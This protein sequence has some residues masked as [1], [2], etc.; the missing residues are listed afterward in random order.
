MVS[1][2]LES[3][4]VQRCQESPREVL[5]L[6]TVWKHKTGCFHHA[7][8]FFLP[9]ILKTKRRKTHQLANM[10][11]IQ[12]STA[13]L[14]T[15]CQLRYLSSQKT[16][17]GGVLGFPTS[18]PSP[19]WKASAAWCY[20]PKVQWMVLHKSVWKI[21]GVLGFGQSFFLLIRETIE[22]HGMKMNK[23]TYVK[24]LVWLS[25]PMDMV[26]KK[27]EVLWTIILEQPLL[28]FGN[29]GN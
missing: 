9:P 19:D 14:R 16:T 5:L 23:Q 11:L 1:S 10:R 2:S 25:H 27:L 21:P 15:L 29:C 20:H 8:S 26:D 12:K 17:G 28:Q 7:G 18:A 6:G 13:Y 3:T 22:K 4:L 24:R